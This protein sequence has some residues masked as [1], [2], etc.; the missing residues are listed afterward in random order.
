DALVELLGDAH[1]LVRRE[2]EARARLLLE[3]RGDE[4]RRGVVLALRLLHRRDDE[5]R[6]LEL[7]L[8]GRGLVGVL[9]PRLLGVE[10]LLAELHELRE[11]A[12]GAELARRSL[13]A[14]GFAFGRRRRRRRS[15]RRVELREESLELPVLD[16][17]EGADLGLALGDELGRD[18]LDA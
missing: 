9:D 11:E 12:A 2:P 15:G 16:R 8:E 7:L 10:L 13:L 6:S 5:G 14:F 17:H 18:R 3:G 4:R 1:G